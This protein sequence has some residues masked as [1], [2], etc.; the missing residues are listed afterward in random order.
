[1]FSQLYF[2]V[3]IQS[4]THYILLHR[5]IN[6]PLL[7]SILFLLPFSRSWIFIFIL[8]FCCK[9]QDFFKT[10]FNFLI[11]LDIIIQNFAFICSW[12]TLYKYLSKL[13][14]RLIKNFYSDRW[15][16]GVTKILRK[17]KCRYIQTLTRAKFFLYH[18]DVFHRRILLYHFGVI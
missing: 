9:G 13:T 5:L 18:F 16:F 14:V 6:P 8:F 7:L 15:I 11:A 4:T 12:Y 3:T 10:V 2:I 1:M 17:P